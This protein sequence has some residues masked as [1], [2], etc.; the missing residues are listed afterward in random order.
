MEVEEDKILVKT[1]EVK[2]LKCDSVVDE[3]LNGK[4]KNLDNNKVED[5]KKESDETKIAKWIS[6]G[7]Y[8]ILT[9]KYP[10]SYPELRTNISN[11]FNYDDS[12]K[13]NKILK[14]KV[15]LSKNEKYMFKTYNILC[16]YIIALEDPRIH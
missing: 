2:E 11:L 8:P 6:S 9:P 4:E 13:F 7:K 5:I 12:E 16:I 1:E 14:W 10:A 3:N 15:T